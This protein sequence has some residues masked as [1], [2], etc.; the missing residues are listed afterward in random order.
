MLVYDCRVFV[1]PC[2]FI[3]HQVVFNLSP[4]YFLIVKSSIMKT[5]SKR[6]NKKLG[7]ASF[8][9]IALTKQQIQQV[10]GGSIRNGDPF[11]G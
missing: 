8:K 2:F 10:K 4:N 11:L 6:Q 1:G 5:N 9:E 7:K 3:A